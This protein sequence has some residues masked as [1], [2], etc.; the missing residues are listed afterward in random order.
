MLVGVVGGTWEE[1]EAVEVYVTVESDFGVS[2]SEEFESGED[3]D[4]A[5]W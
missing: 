1:L 5:P 3:D 2:V 4:V